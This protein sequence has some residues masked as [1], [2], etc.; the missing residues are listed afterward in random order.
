MTEAQIL[1]DEF[2]S[3][4]RHDAVRLLRR[5]R[6]GGALPPMTLKSDTD[7]LDP[8]LT[9]RMQMSQIDYRGRPTVF[10]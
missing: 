4:A 5:M 9:M 6:G 7:L 10:P 3:K 2:R 1:H 8:V